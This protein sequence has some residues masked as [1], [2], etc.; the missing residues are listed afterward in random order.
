MGSPHILV[1]VVRVNISLCIVSPGIDFIGTERAGGC[2]EKNDDETNPY[3]FMLPPGFLK[4][5]FIMD[6][7][8]R[9]SV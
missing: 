6:F 2:K 3:N 9:H 1:A 4:K 7:R 5:T 8:P